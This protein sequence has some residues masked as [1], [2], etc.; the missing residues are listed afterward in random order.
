[1][2]TYLFSHSCFGKSVLS[3]KNFPIRLKKKS[4]EGEE[5]HTDKE[6]CFRVVFFPTVG[7]IPDH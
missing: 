7:N 1:M 2:L 3:R 4:V 5:A 6:I